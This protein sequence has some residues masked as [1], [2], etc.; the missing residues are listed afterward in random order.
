MLT[1]YKNW[2]KIIEDNFDV[3]TMK[4]ECLVMKSGIKL[5]ILNMKKQKYSEALTHKLMPCID[6]QVMR[7]LIHFL[8][9]IFRS[10]LFSILNNS[11]ESMLRWLSQKCQ[12][13]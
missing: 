6:P 2:E 7:T 11:G 4:G 5:Q 13:G 8:D 1:L 10:S 3:T 9:V 12:D